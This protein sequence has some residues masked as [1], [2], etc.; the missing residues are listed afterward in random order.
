MVNKAN[1]IRQSVSK[2][3]YFSINSSAAGSN[4]TVALKA[5][6]N[7]FFST[8]DKDQQSHDETAASQEHQL[9]RLKNSSTEI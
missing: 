2:A 7:Y 1:K 6:V 8:N 5:R 4:H 3:R 9:I